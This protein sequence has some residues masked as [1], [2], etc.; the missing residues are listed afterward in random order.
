MK[1]TK[2]YLNDKTVTN[3]LYVLAVVVIISVII[4]T[5]AAFATQSRTKKPA[6][7]TT[8]TSDVAKM[9]TSTTTKKPSV[10]TTTTTTTKKPDTNP[11][12]TDDNSGNTQPDTDASNNPIELRMPVDGQFAKTFD[13]ENLSYSMTMNDYRTHS[14]VDIVA[15]E[16]SAVFAAEDGTVSALYYDYLMGQC[17]EIDHGNGFVSVYKNLSQ[18]IPEGIAEGAAV[19]KGDIIGA[20]GSSAIIEQ[21]DETHL[22][23]ELEIEGV[24][25]DPLEYIDYTEDALAPSFDY[26]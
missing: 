24:S 8:T 13:I 1:D 19:T 22:H 11:P 23:Y 9:T 17:I 15:E 18:E 5:V 26:E 6:I 4:V 12:Q 16:G 10:T 14:G 7:T 25:V 20:V 3:L 2:K 21:A